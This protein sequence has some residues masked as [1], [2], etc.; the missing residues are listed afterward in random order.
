MK[1]YIYILKHPITKEIRYVGKTTNPKTRLY[2][3]IKL[4][5]IG[6]SHCK[7]WIKSLLV[8]DLKPELEVIAGIND[9]ED[10]R[11]REKYFIKSFTDMGCRLCNH[12]I[13]GECGK[14]SQEHIGLKEQQV[15]N[16]LNFI[17]NGYEV[18]EAEKKAGLSSSYLYK[19]RKGEIA[20]LNHIEVPYFRNLKRNS[21]DKE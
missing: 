11:E 12:T 16:A 3:H 21:I 1:N 17:R 14:L 18:R 5:N 4:V 20:F 10:W 13:G 8:Q 19:V 15:L 6:K 9:E 2:N 7:S